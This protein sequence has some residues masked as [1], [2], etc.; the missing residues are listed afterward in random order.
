M[1][2]VLDHLIVAEGDV[3]QPRLF[4]NTLHNAVAKMRSLGYSHDLASS[5]NTRSALQKLPDPLKERLGERKIETHPT[6]ST[7]VDLDEWLRARQSA[8]TLVSEPL[9]SLSKHSRGGRT[10]YRRPPREGDQGIDKH[11]EQL[12]RRSTLATGAMT[13]NQS[14]PTAKTCLICNKKHKIEKCDKFIAMDVNQRA[15][16]G[17]QKRLCFSCFESADHQSRDCSRKKQCDA[18][19]CN[20][21]H[22]PLIHG[23]APALV[24]PP[25][26]NSAT[27][28]STLNSAAPVFVG[29]SSVNCTPSAVLLQIVPIAVATSSATKV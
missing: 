12:H 21:Y 9:P 20:K 25:R 27:P 2:T 29:G 16:L 3:T 15:Q 7:L 23:A 13:G 5:I 8:K 6:I 22:H 19:G 28:V 26:V 18:K 14:L 24:V 4:Y 10:G 11:Q 1:K 17:K